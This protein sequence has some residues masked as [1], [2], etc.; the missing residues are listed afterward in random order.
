MPRQRAAGSKLAA[1]L[2]KIGK[3]HDAIDELAVGRELEHVDS[4]LA[5]RRAQLGLAALRGSGDSLTPLIF[6][7]VAVVLDSGLNPLFI[8][9]IGPFPRL[10]IAGSAT[11]T[12]I[13]TVM[14]MPERVT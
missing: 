6:M 12:V 4:R 9:G 7:G 1:A 8:A 10:G 14:T 13:A 3:A 5:E 11:A 2:A